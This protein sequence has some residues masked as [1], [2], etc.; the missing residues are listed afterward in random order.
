MD[1]EL[2]IL[3]GALVGA[4]AA[5]ITAKVTTNAQLKIAKLNAK[6]EITLQLDRLYEDRAQRELEVERG[7]LDILHRTLSRI[8]LENSQTMSYMQSDEG[9]TVERFRKRY[10]DNCD[11]LHESL[12]IVDIYYPKMSESLREVYGQSNIFWGYQEN[13]LRIDIK[14]N[15][16]GWQATLSEVLK[17]VET[18]GKRVR[19]L[20]DDIAKR[21]T[22]LAEIARSNESANAEFRSNSSGTLS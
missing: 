11:R 18:I 4:I 21:A 22:F 8:A 13:L 7:K 15:P 12:S 20:Q 5:Y 9:L 6:K 19:Q 1:K 16:K 17:S 2:Y 10:L 14:S 3:V